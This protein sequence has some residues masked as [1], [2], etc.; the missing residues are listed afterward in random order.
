MFVFYV[1][2]YWISC[3]LFVLCRP[4]RQSGASYLAY[5]AGRYAYVPR[6]ITHMSVGHYICLCVFVHAYVYVHIYIYI[7][8]HTWIKRANASYKFPSAP[9]ICV[10]CVWPWPGVCYFQT[11]WNDWPET[12]RTAKYAQQAHRL[13]MCSFNSGVTNHHPLNTIGV[14]TGFHWSWPVC[15]M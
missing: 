9:L 15:F 2:G 6:H 8:I 12:C 11:C 4:G 1:I 5:L 10:S 7:Y 3:C 14:C 13:T